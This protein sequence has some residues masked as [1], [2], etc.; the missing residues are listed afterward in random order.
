[1]KKRALCEKQ[2]SIS[3]PFLS[4]CVQQHSWTQRKCPRGIV[5]PTNKNTTV[6]K[7]KASRLAYAFLISKTTR[8]GIFRVHKRTRN[9]PETSRTGSVITGG[10]GLGRL[11][12][13][14]LPDRLQEVG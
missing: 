9:F 5:L 6:F 13:R 1:M 2:N 10:T 4:R 8:Q 7:W 14:R 3:T 11:Q 12:M